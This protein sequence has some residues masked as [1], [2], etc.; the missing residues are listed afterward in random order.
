MYT[1]RRH[2]GGG[3]DGGECVCVS[4]CV[5]ACVR[6]CERTCVCLHSNEEQCYSQVH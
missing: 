4:A 2:G 1:L 6:A 5:C 3:G